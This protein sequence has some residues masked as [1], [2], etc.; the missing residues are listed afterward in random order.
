MAAKPIPMPSKT[1]PPPV[2]TV[3]TGPQPMDCGVR[4]CGE[5]GTC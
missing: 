4:C 5:S 2:P 1:T 3:G